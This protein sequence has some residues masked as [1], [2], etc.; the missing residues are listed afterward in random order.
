MISNQFSEYY[1][2]VKS[3]L[4]SIG[5]EEYMHKCFQIKLK[6]GEEAGDFLY[7]KITHE[8][9]SSTLGEDSER[10]EFDLEFSGRSLKGKGY[11]Y[12]KINYKIKYD[13]SLED[14][15]SVM[16]K[17]IYMRSLIRDYKL[18]NLLQ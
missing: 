17:N 10:I 13:E 9:I 3:L 16:S 7:Y 8:Y 18:E 2:R 12:I 15:I 11:E 5:F 6:D 14:L 4:E 1:K